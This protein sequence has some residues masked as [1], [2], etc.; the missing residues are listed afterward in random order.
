[1]FGLLARKGVRLRRKL[2][3]QQYAAEDQGE[4]EATVPHQPA[5]GTAISGIV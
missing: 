5:A 1:M 2:R 3:E 4:R